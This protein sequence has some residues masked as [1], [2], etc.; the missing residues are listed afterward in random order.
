VGIWDWGLGGK[1]LATGHWGSG[2]GEGSVCSSREWVNWGR[3]ARVL[4]PARE[5]FALRVE[6]RHRACSE[7][8]VFDRAFRK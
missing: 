8:S 1:G 3:M 4:L 6:A 5:C 7:R 2:W